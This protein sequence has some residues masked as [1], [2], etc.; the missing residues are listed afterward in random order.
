MTDRDSAA[1]LDAKQQPVAAAEA[2][3]AA[4][5]HSD[6]ESGAILIKLFSIGP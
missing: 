5:A 2:Y 1:A 3:Q 6:A 4:I